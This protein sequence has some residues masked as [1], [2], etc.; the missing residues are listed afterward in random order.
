V[1]VR[2]V[3]AATVP[4]KKV[5]LP[6]CIVT[7]PEVNPLPDILTNVPTVPEV[8]EREIVGAAKTG[9][10]GNKTASMAIIMAADAT[11][12]IFLGLTSY[13]PSSSGQ[14]IRYISL[15]SLA[16]ITGI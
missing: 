3:S 7:V 11:R 8:V 6:K 16:Q 12:K 9:I 2:V 13:L 10:A 14:Y 15:H 1:E 5:S 4:E